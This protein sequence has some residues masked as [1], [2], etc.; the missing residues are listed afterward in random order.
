MPLQSITR[1]VVTDTITFTGKP[2]V[3]V[4]EKLR[5]AGFDFDRRSLQWFRKDDQASVAGEQEVLASIGAA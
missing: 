2:S 3:E 5:A 1:R 4:T